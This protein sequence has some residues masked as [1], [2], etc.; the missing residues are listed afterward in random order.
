MGG[1]HLW[2]LGAI[3]Y[4]LVIVAVFDKMNCKKILYFLTPL[5]LCGDLILGKYSL[6]LWDREF[7]VYV[8]RNFIFV[9][10]PYFCIGR[11]IRD[12]SMEKVKKRTLVI[13][14]VCFSGTSLIE[15]YILVN[16][17]MNAYRDHYI[18]TTFLAVAVFLLFFKVRRS[19]KTSSIIGR[20]YSTW[21]YV[22]H[23]I[24]ISCISAFIRM[25]DLFEIYEFI[26]PFIIYLSTIIFLWIVFRIKDRVMKYK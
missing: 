2:Y 11:V 7:P 18:S 14:V 19:N 26:A 21:I 23:P 22:L 20:D 25:V 17:G 12:R 9:G 3:L 16:I 1:G 24:F 6:V 13:F 5:L 15:H 4:V 8:V 10:L